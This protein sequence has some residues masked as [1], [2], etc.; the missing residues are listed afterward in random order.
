[1]TLPK[2][3]HILLL[4]PDTMRSFLILAAI[5]VSGSAQAQFPYNY[6]PYT[7]RYPSTAHAPLAED[8]S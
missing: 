5:A 1:V 3:S 4:Q 2:P 8:R 6:A 7:R